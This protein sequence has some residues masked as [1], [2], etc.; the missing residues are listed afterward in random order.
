[1]DTQTPG[2]GHNAPPDLL[3]VEAGERVDVANRWLTERK[4]IGDAE[5]ADKA[6]FFVTQ[7]DATH[8]ALDG[9]RLEEGR[10][11]KAAQ[12]AKYGKPLSL[13]VLAK[14][15]LV[16]M[17]R[18]WLKKE[19]ARLAEE[20]R[21]A[22]AKIEAA[23]KEA[24]EAAARALKEANKKNGDPL[25]AQIDAEEAAAKVR[26]AEVAAEQKAGEKAQIKGVYTTKAVG[27]REIWG[28]EIVDFAAAFKTYKKRPEV[29]NAIKEAMEKVAKAD[30]QKLKDINAAPAGVKYT[31]EKR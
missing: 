31:V 8:K 9:Q 12:D 26:L 18:E 21:V 29:V 22:E 23:R 4:E 14:T 2:I 13:L 24:E 7:I 20:R 3:I 19:D 11:F 6:S 28:A 16:N 30:A 25:R 17:R 27:L 15:S 5:T 1:M 10:V